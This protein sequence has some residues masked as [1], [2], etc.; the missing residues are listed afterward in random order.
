MPRRTTCS[1]RTWP[2]GAGY[3]RPYEFADGQRR[4]KTAEYPPAL[5][6]T[7]AI[8]TKLGAGSETSQRVLLCGVGALTVGLVGLI[9]RRLGGDGAGYLAAA[10]GRGAPRRSGTTTSSLMA[11][12]LAAFAGAAVVLAALAV[13][14]PARPLA[15]GGLGRGRWARAA[16]CAPSSCSSAW[17]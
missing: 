17:G 10:R 15:L 3:I 14:R 4:I 7:L 12:P 11:E 5:P 2:T 9:G 13:A 1:A 8:A 6:V 16:W